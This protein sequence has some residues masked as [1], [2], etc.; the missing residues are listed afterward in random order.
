MKKKL[1]VGLG[2]MVWVV[3]STAVAEKKYAP[4]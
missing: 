4:G 3:V 2:L 1:L